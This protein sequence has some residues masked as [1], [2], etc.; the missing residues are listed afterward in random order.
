MVKEFVNFYGNNLV[1]ESTL[2]NGVKKF[3]IWCKDKNPYGDFMVI[4]MKI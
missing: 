2:I 4:F 3:L 1:N